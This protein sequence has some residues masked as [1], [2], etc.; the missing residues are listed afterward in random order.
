[1]FCMHRFSISQQARNL[2]QAP[3]VLLRSEKQ[4]PYD[5]LFSHNKKRV[6]RPSRASL[7]R[8][9]QASKRAW[10]S[11]LG[12]RSNSSHGQRSSWLAPALVLLLL[13][14]LLVSCGGPT[15][16]STPTPTVPPPFQLT[17]FDLHLPPAALNAPVLGP[18]PDTKLLH[19]SITFKANQQLLAQLSKQK[20]QAGQPQ[21]L[22]NLAN[23][24]GITDQQYQ[25]LKA[26]FGVRDASLNLNKLHTVLTVD[27]KAKT[28]AQ[29][30]QVQFVQHQLNG[31]TF[32]A[33]STNPKIPSSI[34]P[35]VLAITGLDNYS[36][37]PQTH[38]FVRFSTGRMI[39]HARLKRSRNS[40]TADCNPALGT[41]TA[42]DVA[43][44]Y[45]Y[46]QLQQKG[47]NGKGITINL[48]E[49]DRFDMA[50]VQNYASCVNYHGS[51]TVMPTNPRP[52][53]DI[54][55]TIDIETI[56]GLAPNAN[57]IDY[58]T[59][60]SSFFGLN[61]QLQAI[62]NN[63]THNTS[64]GSIVSISIGL[65]ETGITQDD[66]AAIDQSLQI[67]TQA[68]HITIFVAS[69]DCAAFDDETFGHLSVD[70]P[71][72]DP[73]TVAVGGTQ[74]VLDQNNNINEVAWSDSSAN[75]NM[76]NNNWGSGGGL[77]TRFKLP[78]WQSGPG[79]LNKFSN[80]MRQ[81]PEVSAF[82]DDLAGYYQGQW[83][84]FGGT[85]FAT[86]IWAS[87][88]ALVNEGLLQTKQSFL[89]GPDTFYRV[90]A[91]SIG[92]HLHPYHDITQGNNLYYP[93]TTAWDFPSGF[94]T[95]NLP[96]FYQALLAL[97]GNTRSNT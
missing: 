2:G 56:M 4:G 29:L 24:L 59:N 70:F 21:N 41:L 87:G 71:S 54:E 78:R 53:P 69:G 76:C 19:V 68:E 77:S 97:A 14:G 34:A 11:L 65:Y 85:S 30:F 35:M 46:D 60:D 42:T 26:Y 48:I 38:S 15:P 50:D 96:D 9:A 80:G 43:K 3:S 82:A 55:S 32:Y 22:E 45:G 23:Q 67:L 89:Y 83:A 86:P 47:L 8:Q 57:I 64:S 13:L 73:W 95:P 7:T 81:T 74:P 37:P 75:K 39:N 52:M 28:F 44:Q 12:A 16:V 1:M 61:N 51:L 18:L 94:G 36:L 17:T 63:N 40:T 79:V 72:V 31:R 88:L 49:I 25:Q 66:V 93:T 92:L 6:V 91:V 10:A 5:S 62:I 90:I 84:I 27:A 20:I 33:P 58:E